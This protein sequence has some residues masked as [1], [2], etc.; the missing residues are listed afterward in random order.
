MLTQIRH[1][2]CNF[3]TTDVS[4]ARKVRCYFSVYEEEKRLER[5]NGCFVTYS[6]GVAT[7]LHVDK[8]D[9][10][11]QSRSSVLGHYIKVSLKMVNITNLCSGRGQ[12]LLYGVKRGKIPTSLRPRVLPKRRDQGR[13]YE[14]WK[15]KPTEA[16]GGSKIPRVVSGIMEHLREELK[17]SPQFKTNLATLGISD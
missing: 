7:W 11:T 1:Q 12:S 17:S 3:G 5:E 14:R 4:A 2:F 8:Y 13:K 6:K 9:F 16:A 10:K 15:P